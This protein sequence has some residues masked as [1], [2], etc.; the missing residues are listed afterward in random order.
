MEEGVVRQV[1]NSKL[2]S[3]FNNKCFVTGVSGS[4]NNWLALGGQYRKLGLF[5]YDMS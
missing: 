4:G 2:G 1:S 3:L 5:T